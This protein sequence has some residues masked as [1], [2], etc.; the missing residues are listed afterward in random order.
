MG[1]RRSY[2]V[3][4]VVGKTPNLRKRLSD[5]AK[6]GSGKKTAQTAID[7]YSKSPQVVKD[8]KTAF[9]GIELLRRNVGKEP[10]KWKE[11][12]RIARDFWAKEKKKKKL[13]TTSQ[14]DLIIVSSLTK[15]I[16]RERKK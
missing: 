6:T 12:D 3:D 9:A 11:R 5:S 2:Y 15:S 13:D 8:L 14:L 10:L 4:V 1:G 7:I 16:R